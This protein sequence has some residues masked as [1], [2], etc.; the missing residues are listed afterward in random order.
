MGGVREQRREEREGGERCWLLPPQLRIRMISLG[1]GA[2]AKR[3][4]HCQVY[5]RSIYKLAGVQSGLHGRGDALLWMGE[6]TKR[7]GNDIVPDCACSVGWVWSGLVYRRL[8]GMAV[9]FT[10]MCFI[11]TI[12]WGHCSK[13]I[14]A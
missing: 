6:A 5:L 3:K 13:N 4:G 2:G 12:F 11:Q 8:W 7:R 9:C 10:L 1:W 14:T